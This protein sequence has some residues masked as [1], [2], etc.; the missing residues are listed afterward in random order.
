MNER[1]R[2][3][4]F[5]PI[6]DRPVEVGRSSDAG[7]RLIHPTVSRNHATLTRAV[8]GIEVVDR[9]SR[10]GTFVNGV[11]VRAACAR[12][13]DRI[14]FGT[15]TAYRVCGDG[16]RLDSAARGASIAAAGLTVSKGGKVLVRDAGFSIP[17][18]CFVGILGPSGAGKS[19]LLNCIASYHRAGVGRIV[20]DNQHDINEARDEYRESWDTS[21]KTMLST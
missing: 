21:P 1:G 7:L 13:G 18:D 11:R 19:T 14:Q 8:E 5:M 20:F 10:F 17:A 4:E 16:L 6:G 2:D 15:A 3:P 9:D 12:P